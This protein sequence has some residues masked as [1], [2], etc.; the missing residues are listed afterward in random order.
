[1]VSRTTECLSGMKKDWVLG[2]F[3]NACRETTTQRTEN[4]VRVRVRVRVGLGCRERERWSR[5]CCIHI[6]VA[7]EKSEL[8]KLMPGR[9]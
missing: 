5:A 3:K 1:M 8:T 7:T 6:N 4:R 9:F 2:S